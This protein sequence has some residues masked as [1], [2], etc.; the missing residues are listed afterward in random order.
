MIKPRTDDIDVSAEM[1]GHEKRLIILTRDKKFIYILIDEDRIK[2]LEVETPDDIKPGDIFAAKVAGINKSLSGAFVFLKHGVQGYIDNMN[3]E[4]IFL[5]NRKYD[6]VLKQGDELFVS[7]KKEGSGNKV[8]LCAPLKETA[9]DFYNPG[10]IYKTPSL[11]KQA[12]C[13]LRKIFSDMG[14]SKDDTGIKVV[15]DC[16]HSFRMAKSVLNDY[17]VEIKE[18]K[19]SKVSLDVIYGLKSKV[20]RITD[21]K[22]WLK[23][24]GYLYIDRT[25]AMYVIDVN[26]GKLQEKNREAGFIV[27]SLEAID[28][29]VYQIEARNLSGIIV[30]DMLKINNEKDKTMLINTFSEK[31]ARLNPP[32]RLADVTKLGLY[33]ITRQKL[34]PDINEQ[35][36]RLGKTILL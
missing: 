21:D 23:S 35:L 32:G 11:Y 12:D 22:V 20:E 28:E 24:G 3:P 30:V 17:S 2:R 36:K 27:T 6:G 34:R 9:C 7:V 26:S 25:R 15:C 5:L 18:H 4:G 1:K 29:I 16:D 33:E 10:L 19:E 8:P 13:C 31:L 14:V